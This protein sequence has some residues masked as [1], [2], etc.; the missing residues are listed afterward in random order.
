MRSLLGAAAAALLF[1]SQ[2]VM[3]QGDVE[4]E[5]ETALA[6]EGGGES[7]AEKRREDLPEI[8]EDKLAIFELQRGFYLSSD[9]GVFMTFGGTRSYSN[10]QP[11]LSLKAGFDIGDY[12]SVQAALSA[13]YS[14]G[15]PISKNDL[16]G[17]GGRE[18]VS[19]SLFNAG[20]EV[21][22]AVRPTE[23]FAIEPKV[24]GGITMLSPEPT[25]PA[26]IDASVGSMLPHVSGGLDF[27]YLTL[28]TDF[29][30]GVSLTGYIILGPNI[31]AGAAAFVVR[32][33]L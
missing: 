17:A 26:D 2:P 21:V 4:D 7:A 25:D 32:Y 23:R 1:V 12:V 11:F 8:G 20:A 33:T 22:A 14:S 30:A 18:V 6:D 16:P 15:N 29:S 9:L 3:A 28:L 13:G 31:P 19:F 10:A 24:G 27:K 5:V